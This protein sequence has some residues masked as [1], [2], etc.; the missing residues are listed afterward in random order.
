[1]R[2][3][4]LAFVFAAGAAMLA[5]LSQQASAADLPDG[6]G[7][8][9]KDTPYVVVPWQGLYFGGHAGGAWGNTGLHDTFTYVGDPTV[10]AKLASTGLIAGGQVGYNV[11]RGHFVFGLESDIGYLGISAGKSANGLSAPAGE[12]KHKYSD[13]SFTTYYDPK[14]CQVDAKYSSSSDLYGDLTARFGYAMDRTLLYVKGGVAL[15]D[16]DVKAHY[17][18]QNCLTTGACSPAPGSKVGTSPFD[19]GQS[20]TLV[21][22]TIGAGAEYALSPSW[23]LKAEYQHFDFGSM[24]YSYNPAPYNIPCAASTSPKCVSHAADHYTSTITG[25]TDVSLGADAVK[26]GINYHVGGE[27]GLK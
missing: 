11:Q 19:V 5:P 13:E 10:D 8:G 16:A 26:F 2:M 14:M 18:G 24:S 23:S 9:Y 27:G 20:A 12:C 3:F 21:G 22:W 7:G 25:K 15:L 1:M 4:R 17:D 6:G